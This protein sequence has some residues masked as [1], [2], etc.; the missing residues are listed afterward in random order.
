MKDG[1][2]IQND[3]E[4]AMK[5]GLDASHQFLDEL[6]SK[7]QS[8]NLLT[9]LLGAAAR[10]GPLEIV[11]RLATEIPP[12]SRQSYALRHACSVPGREDIIKFL[13]P[14]SDPED[15]RSEAFTWAAER[16]YLEAVKLLA[17][18]SNT[19]A[20]SHAGFLMAVLNG[21]LEVV[22]FLAPL[23]DVQFNQSQALQ[24]ASETNHFEVFHFL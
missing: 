19:R 5:K 9:D 14:L 4:D 1:Y 2:Q 15:H 24:I 6:L 21:H 7:E 10:H 12:K 18:V 13:I 11:K 20:R 17:P 22:R 8:K 16:G 3:F 23:V